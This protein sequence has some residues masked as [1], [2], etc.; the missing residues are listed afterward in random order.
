MLKPIKTIAGQILLYF[1]YLHRTNPSLLSEWMMSFNKDTEKIAIENRTNT[2]VIDRVKKIESNDIDIINALEYLG[3][4]G[5]IVSGDPTFDMSG[6]GSFYN[7][8]LTSQ[9]ID[10]IENIE[11]SASERKNFEINFNMTVNNNVNVESL[12]KAELGSLF[13]G[14]I[15]G[16]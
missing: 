15:F 11:R 6:N 1:Y 12:L 2:E 9:G 13:K 14:S 7:I 10:I 16:L 3:E 5:F 4:K 8:K